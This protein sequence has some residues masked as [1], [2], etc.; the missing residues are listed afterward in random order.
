MSQILCMKYKKISWMRLIC[1]QY[2]SKYSVGIFSVQNRNFS[3][4][5][6][7]FIYI[8]PPLRHDSSEVISFRLS[9]NSQICQKIPF[10]SSLV[11]QAGRT[12]PSFL[13]PSPD[14][15]TWISED[16]FDVTHLFTDSTLRP[17]TFR[18]PHRSPHS[19]WRAP[20]RGGSWPS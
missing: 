16:F 3:L 12:R 13:L 17:R 14:R 10:Q 19:P 20:G 9:T 5:I 11:R 15:W 1:F 6:L 8:F 18:L 2:D 4:Q 7:I